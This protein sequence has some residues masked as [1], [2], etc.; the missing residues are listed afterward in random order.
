[1][2]GVIERLRESGD[3][4]SVRSGAGFAAPGALGREAKGAQWYRAYCLAG[5]THFAIS[6]F[7]LRDV[8]I[9]GS[10]GRSRARA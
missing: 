6:A 1:V 10:D 3:E 9:R 5:A 8:V 7:A 4:V 2:D